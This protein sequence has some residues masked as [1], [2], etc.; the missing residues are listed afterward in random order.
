MLDQVQRFIGA[1]AS[2]PPHQLAEHNVLY[3]DN[4]AS[5]DSFERPQEAPSYPEYVNVR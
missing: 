3:R 1:P 5:D 4:Y 2:P